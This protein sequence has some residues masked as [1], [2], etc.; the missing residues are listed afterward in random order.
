MRPAITRG[1]WIEGRPA[2]PPGEFNLTAFLTVSEQ[3]FDTA[4]IRLLRGR[5]ITRDDNLRSPDV[6]VVNE[7]FARRYFPGQD[8]IGKRIAYGARTDDHYWR[9]I[10]G[11]AA[12]TREQ[13]GQPAESHDVRAVPPGARSVYVRGISRQDLVAGCDRRPNGSAR[14]V[15]VRSGSADLSPAACRGG[16]ARVDCDRAVHD[17]HCDDVRGSG[18][19]ARGGRHVW[20]DE[21]CGAEPHEGNRRP[22]GA[23][24]DA[25]PSSSWCSAKRAASCWHRRSSGLLRRRRWALD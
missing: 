25:A 13:L 8:P 6:V 15:G 7:A 16:Y 23:R 24:R 21:P 5:A 22:D 4:G 1:V 9:T 18:A 11:L 14:S 10:V 20:R 2:P 19:G 17:A 3:Y 12:D